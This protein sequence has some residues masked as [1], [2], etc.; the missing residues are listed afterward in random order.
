MYVVIL[1]EH[2]AFIFGKRTVW[3]CRFGKVNLLRHKYYYSPEKTKT[4]FLG[5]TMDTKMSCLACT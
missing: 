3:K 2:K 1:T 4:L 5:G